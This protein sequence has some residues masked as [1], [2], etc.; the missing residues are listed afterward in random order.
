[1][2]L[3]EF[4]PG[5]AVVWLKDAQEPGSNFPDASHPVLAS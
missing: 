5:V 2:S 4:G 1:M 3:E